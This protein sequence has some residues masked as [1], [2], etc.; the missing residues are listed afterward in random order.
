VAEALARYPSLTVEGY[1]NDPGYNDTE[2][3]RL[4]DTMRQAGFPLCASEEALKL[5]PNIKRLPECVSS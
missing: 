1:V 3:Q 5:T 2:R 4:T